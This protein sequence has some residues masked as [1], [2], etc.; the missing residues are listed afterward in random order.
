MARPKKQT[1]DYFTHDCDCLNKKTLY[2]IDNKFGND[3][4]AFWFKLLEILG[5]TEGHY[6]NCNDESNWY[7]LLAKTHLEETKAL[8]IINSLV[9]LEAI[10]KELWDK[11]IIWSKNFINRLEDV[12]I[13]RK[14]DLPKKPNLNNNQEKNDIFNKKVWCRN[15]TNKS[16]QKGII[17]KKPCKVCGTDKNIEV[18]HY[19]Y[20]DPLDIDFYC[21]LHH[22]QYHKENDNKYGI[23]ANINTNNNENDN[24]NVSINPQIKLKYS[25]VNKININAQFEEWYK[26]YPNKK[27]KQKASEY[28]YKIINSGEAT[29]DQLNFAVENYAAEITEKFKNDQKFKIDFVAHA[30]SFLGPQKKYKDYL[31]VHSRDSPDKQEIKYKTVVYDEYTEKLIDPERGY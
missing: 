28:F 8:E 7:Y 5:S 31:Q 30:S 19:N 12:Y 16:I 14:I 11:K 13:R 2:I 18:H 25:K 9:N 6:F 15:A 24:I 21:M 26:K 10:D 3:G 4:Y 22:R 1:V 20:D 27:G 17:E 29:L 23:N